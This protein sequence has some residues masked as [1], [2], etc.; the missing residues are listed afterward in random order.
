MS[1]CE[2]L[3]SHGTIYETLC[4]RFS[5]ELKLRLG[6]LRFITARKVKSGLRTS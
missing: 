1:D 6:Y 3:G 5:V 4:N 2:Q